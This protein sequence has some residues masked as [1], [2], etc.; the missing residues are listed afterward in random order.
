MHVYDC[1]CMF[2]SLPCM[3]YL[4]IFFKINVYIRHME[5]CFFLF[6]SIFFV[7]KTFNICHSMCLSLPIQHS[8]LFPIFQC[9]INETTEN[10][11]SIVSRSSILAF[12][13]RFELR[14]VRLSIRVRRQTQ[15][16]SIAQYK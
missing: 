9:N 12:Q 3:L 16:G 1:K 14:R 4:F 11:I 7:N 10:E 2:C 13:F 5:N 6:H 15:F 8:K